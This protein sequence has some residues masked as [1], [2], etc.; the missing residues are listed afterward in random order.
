MNR[1]ILFTQ[2]NQIYTPSY[3]SNYE[4]MILDIVGSDITKKQDRNYVI[5]YRDGYNPIGVAKDGGAA[6]ETIAVYIPSAS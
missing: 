3:S 4:N 1:T 5:P 2:Q 6:G